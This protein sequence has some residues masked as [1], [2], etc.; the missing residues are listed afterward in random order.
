MTRKNQ[1]RTI[2]ELYSQGGNILEYFNKD[3]PFRTV[4]EIMISYDFQAG[5]YIQGYEKNIKDKNL[6]CDEIANVIKNLG[7]F[8]TI[9]EV[10]VGEATTLARVYSKM[11]KS[12]Q[13]YGFDVSWSRIKYG[14][15]FLKD[16][17]AGANLFVA[18]LFN[19][20]L[21]NNSIDVVYTSHSLEPNGGRELEALTELIRVANKYVVLLEP[22][23]ELSDES[24][25][26]R[27]RTLGY[28]KDLRRNIDLLDV[29]VLYYGPFKYNA[30]RKENPTGLIILEKESQE[31]F[32]KEKFRCPST[33]TNIIK[34]DLGDYYSPETG[35]VYPSLQG[36]PLLSVEHAIV[37]THYKKFLEGN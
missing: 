36:I 1:L 31:V 22:I 2:K 12:I 37:A 11:S 6:Y 34:S 13:A 4:E 29:K 17:G 27:M 3:N 33:F 19:I 25:Q 28:I 24:Q 26:E 32:I 9:L 5:T 21:K 18:D 10:G 35:V 23:Y 7:E 15:E 14:M 8:S 20:P 30:G 16:K